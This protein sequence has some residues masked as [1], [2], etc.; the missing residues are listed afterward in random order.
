MEVCKQLG[1]AGAQGCVGVKGIISGRSWASGRARE[2]AW[3]SLFALGR[4]GAFDAEEA[5]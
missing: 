5:L 1:L 2:A 3:I 4:G